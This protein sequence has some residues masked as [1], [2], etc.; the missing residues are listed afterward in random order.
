MWRRFKIWIAKGFTSKPDY[1]ELRYDERIKESEEALE[2]IKKMLATPNYK[3]EFIALKDSFEAL[4]Q[5]IITIED[6]RLA[7]LHRIELEFPEIQ[8]KYRNVSDAVEYLIL[9][10]KTHPKESNA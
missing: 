4:T 7:V 8:G 1:L 6:E 9:K 10:A 3:N 2:K 5:S